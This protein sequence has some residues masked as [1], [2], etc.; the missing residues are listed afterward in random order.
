MLSICTHAR[1]QL[2]SPV[3]DVRVNNVPLQTVPDINKA[4][5]QLIDTGHTSFIYSLLHNTP[6]FIVHGIQVWA[7]WWPEIRPMKSSVS[8]CSCLMVFLHDEMQR[9]LVER[10]T[11]RLQHAWSLA[12][13]AERVKHRGNTGRWLLFQVRQRSTQSYPFSTHQWKP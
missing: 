7:V 8:C 12:A 10:Q 5:L 9:C 3:V 11:Y 13:S 1:S 2:F 6:D 4:L